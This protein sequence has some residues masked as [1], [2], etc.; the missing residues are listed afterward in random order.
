M[1]S[2]TPTLGPDVSQAII[3]QLRAN[4]SIGN[5][6]PMLGMQPLEQHQLEQLRS[7]VELIVREWMAI[8]FT[9]V[10]QQDPRRA[11]AHIVQSVCIIILFS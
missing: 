5:A 7:K 9:S 11:L 1:T 6:T 4:R 10:T 2:T 3:E 8:C